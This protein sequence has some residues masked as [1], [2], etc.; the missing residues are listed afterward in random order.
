MAKI[1]APRGVIPRPLSQEKNAGF[2]ATLNPSMSDLPAGERY[3]YQLFSLIETADL[4][5]INPEGKAFHFGKAGLSLPLCL[6]IHNPSLY[7][8]PLPILGDRANAEPS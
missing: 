3:L 6:Q 1:D 7:D 4:T 8:R 2:T 5:V